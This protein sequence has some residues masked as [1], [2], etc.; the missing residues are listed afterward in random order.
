MYTNLCKPIRQQ[1][2]FAI[3]RENG[4]VRQVGRSSVLLPKTNYRK[5]SGSKWFYDSRNLKETR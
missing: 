5:G 2:T 3:V 1:T 4:I